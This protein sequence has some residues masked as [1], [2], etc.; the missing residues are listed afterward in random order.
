[1]ETAHGVCGVDVFAGV[2]KE[3]VNPRHCV[4]PC[5]CERVVDVLH[6]AWGICVCVCAHVRGH[7]GNACRKCDVQG[8][9]P[10]VQE[11]HEDHAGV[12]WQVCMCVTVHD[13]NRDTRKDG[14]SP[15]HPPPHV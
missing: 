12:G 8:E 6:R 9:A 2:C 13:M 5:L 15:E 4:C 1:M 7:V 11:G 3:H 10:E 14:C